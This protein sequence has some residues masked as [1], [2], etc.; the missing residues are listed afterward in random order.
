MFNLYTYEKRLKDKEQQEQQK[1]KNIINRELYVKN[2]DK[3][4][5]KFYKKMNKFLFEMIKKPIVINNT[6][7]Q[8]KEKKNNNSFCLFKFQTD[9]ERIEKLLNSE[10]KFKN[11]KNKNSDRK[12][13]RSQSNII[14]DY[15]KYNEELNDMD[16]DVDIY[17]FN[18]SSNYKNKNIEDDIINQPSMKFKPRN[19]F[20]RILDSINM[21]QGL[22][23]EDKI[24]KINKKY[25][26][27]LFDQKQKEKGKNKIKKILVESN[28][29][30]NNNI[31][32]DKDILIAF[33]K[34]TTNNSDKINQN[35]ILYYKNLKLNKKKNNLNDKINLSNTVKN[36]TERYHSKTYFNSIEQ[37]IMCNIQKNKKIISKIKTK[38]NIKN[39]KNKMN[40]S[41][42]AI[43]FFPHI[44]KNKNNNIDPG[45]TKGYSDINR[46]T[47]I[48]NNKKKYKNNFR[49][50]EYMNDDINNNSSN[51]SNNDIN[52]KEEIIEQI[53][54]LNDPGFY[55][56]KS[57]KLNKNQKQNLMILKK[58][59]INKHKVLFSDR[60]S[61]LFFENSKGFLLDHDIS[62]TIK[63]IRNL[64]SNNN[65]T[66]IEDDIYIIFNNCIYNK[67]N[68]EDLNNLGK[69]VLKK[70]HFIK[71]KYDDDENNQLKKGKGKLM[72]TNGLP[73][74][75]F[76]NKYS[77][78]NIN[79]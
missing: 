50:T 29:N 28:N 43:N 5:Q 48:N 32:N 1:T 77:L 23:K 38:N 53:L 76:L 56:T 78:P 20:E 74:K 8:P 44:N 14:N 26:K 40:Y 36:I 75:D 66:I 69:E 25:G 49:K 35:N 63:N 16:I 37:A 10:L 12:I 30:S 79:K 54:K 62:N 15:I 41:S 45:N 42:S 21:N 64:N 73:I 51:T 13:K 65:K 22:I 68:K 71:T 18:I 34:K 39:S 24:T 70:C 61:N 6:Y 2:R 4:A 59:A 19:D 67:K 17:D 57:N 52:K 55:N 46:Y 27:K 31:I 58:M 11:E 7:Y 47:R 72:I 33:D 60:K 9:R 3:L